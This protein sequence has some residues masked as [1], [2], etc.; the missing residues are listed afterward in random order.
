MPHRSPRL[1]KKNTPSAE[2]SPDPLAARLRR[3]CAQRGWDWAELARRAEISRTTL[4]HWEQG[5]T[6]RPRSKTLHKI[7]AALG[8][9]IDD[10]APSKPPIL[11]Q[12]P[13]STTLQPSPRTS[14][15]PA[16]LQQV[17]QAHPELTAGWTEENLTEMCAALPS[18]SATLKSILSTIESINRARLTLRKLHRVMQTHMTGTAVEL[19]ETLHRLAFPEGES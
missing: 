10:L 6:G 9:G 4:Y 14:K 3:E 5:R 7:A 18:D 13:A 8:I 16:S 11:K 1:P 19:V 2:I 17:V 12:T 15:L